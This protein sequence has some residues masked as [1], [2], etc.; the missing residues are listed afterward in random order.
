MFYISILMGLFG[1]AGGRAG[2]VKDA[3]A[4]SF[5]GYPILTAAD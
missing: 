1:Q 2:S 5:P 4:P 3:Q